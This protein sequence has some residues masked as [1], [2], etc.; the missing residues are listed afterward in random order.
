M[1]NGLPD[2]GPEL[3]QHTMVKVCSRT[4]PFSSEQENEAGV[5]M[6]PSREYP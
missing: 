3:K 6:S 1:I 5:L 2:F 4:K